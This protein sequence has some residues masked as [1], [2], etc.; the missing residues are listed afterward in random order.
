MI[1]EIM[2]YNYMYNT[3]MYINTMGAKQGDRGDNRPFI[4]PWFLVNIQN[5]SM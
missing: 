2:I 5:S 4:P 1:M 3:N